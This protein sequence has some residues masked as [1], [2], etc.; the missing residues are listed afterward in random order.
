MFEF[1]IACLCSSGF[2]ESIEGMR[3]DPSE[4][5]EPLFAPP[6]FF[7]FISGGESLDQ[8]FFYC[9]NDVFEI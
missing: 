2:W 1:W 4:L 8:G 9:D 6:Y 7:S 5:D 3:D